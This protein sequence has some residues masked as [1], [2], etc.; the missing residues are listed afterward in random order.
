MLYLAAFQALLGRLAGREDL[1][2]GTP[3]AGRTRPELEGLIGLFVNTLALRGEL[4]GD[5]SFGEQLARVR[6]ASLGA[7]AHQDLPFERLV[8]ELAPERNLTHAPVFQVLF[9]FQNAAPA[10]LALPGLTWSLL[11][12][13]A[14]TAKFD[15]TLT[16]FED[17][18]GLG[19]S[20]AS[21]ATCST[22]RR[23]GAG[24]VT[25]GCCWPG[26]PASRRSGCR[27][28]P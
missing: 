21:I 14:G 10:V 3:I 25:W 8:Q 9:V 13:D 12:V 16:L 7:Y 27:K 6:E 15:L 24:R 18:E 5:P 26:W 11:D 22:T 1:V 4:S 19:G 23:Y 17:G 28:G 20:S 2:V